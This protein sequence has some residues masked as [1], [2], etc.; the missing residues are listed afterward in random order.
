MTFEFHPDE[1]LRRGVRRLARAELEAGIAELDTWRTQPDVAIHD[2]RRRLKRV[3]ALLH[4]VRAVF[5]RVRRENAAV[6]DAARLLAPARDATA[7]IQCL[8]DLVEHDPGP[9]AT[10]DVATLR[11]V[12]VAR[13]DDA[14][15]PKRL[16][17]RIG[18]AREILEAVHRR[19]RGWT[20]S[21]RDIDAAY[22]GLR[23]SYRDGRRVLGLAMQDPDAE[24]FHDWRKDVK[25]LWYQVA[26]FRPLAPR[27]VARVHDESGRL[28]WTLGH[29]HDLTTLRRAVTDGSMP[30]LDDRAFVVLVDAIDR[31]RT[32][33]RRLALRL[34]RTLYDARP[35]EFI[36]ALRADEPE[37]SAEPVH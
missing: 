1:S 2:V 33:D 4:L 37:P 5:P 17:R 36:A 35:R 13:H 25:S 22:D 10:T 12:F 20:V 9:V 3:R 6:R 21:T 11:A 24:D 34:G 23:R 19:A 29:E 30:A 28:G 7:R 8:D 31:R 14:S 15:A 32:A 16:K 27:A 18:E 26:L